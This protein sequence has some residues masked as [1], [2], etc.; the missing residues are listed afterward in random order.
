VTPLPSGSNGGGGSAPVMHPRSS[1]P[2]VNLSQE[3]VRNAKGPW[4][5]GGEARNN[6]PD[7]DVNSAPL[8]RDDK[9]PPHFANEVVTC[10]EPDPQ[11]DDCLPNFQKHV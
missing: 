7:P 9:K 10:L 8:P 3:K 5:V 2:Y 11:P 1:V 4:E 6:W